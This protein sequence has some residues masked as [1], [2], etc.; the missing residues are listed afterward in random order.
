VGTHQRDGSG[1]SWA[2]TPPQVDPQRLGSPQGTQPYQC[3]PH[4]SWRRGFGVEG[5]EA[6][7]A[8]RFQGGGPAAQH[9][10]DGRAA[11]HMEHGW[12]RDTCG[13]HA[14]ARGWKGHVDD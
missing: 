14:W 8:A 6:P 12:G 7:V 13:Y 11:Q 10:E 9:A 4:A 5:P 3:R 2:L 1:F